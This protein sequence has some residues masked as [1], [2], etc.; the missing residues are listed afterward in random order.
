M[1]PTTHPLY[2][3]LALVLAGLFAALATRDGVRR[4][5]AIQ[6]VFAGAT[7]GFVTFARHWGNHEGQIAAVLAILLAFAWSLVGL[8]V[9]IRGREGR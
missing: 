4:V 7:L 9:A 8:R 5:F 2:F 3:A 1:F 6:L